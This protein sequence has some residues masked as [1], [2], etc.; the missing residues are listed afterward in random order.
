MNPRTFAAAGAALL[1]LLSCGKIA[2]I[3]PTRLGG[4]PA[5]NACETAKAER[6]VAE[7]EAENLRDSYRAESRLQGGR[8]EAINRLSLDAMNLRVQAHRRLHGKPHLGLAQVV[9]ILPSP[10]VDIFSGKNA[11]AS[12]RDATG[13]WWW[14][15]KTQFLEHNPLE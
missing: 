10:A 2:E 15:E 3:L 4:A 6:V 13:G 8:K 5:T 1:A 9:Q 14:N 7:V 11:I 12:N